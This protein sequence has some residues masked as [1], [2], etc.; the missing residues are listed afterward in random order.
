MSETLFSE[1]KI[2]WV[3]ATCD[4]VQKNGEANNVVCECGHKMDQYSGWGELS[5]WKCTNCDGDAQFM[6]DKLH[7]PWLKDDERPSV[8][9]STPHEDVIDKYQE[10]DTALTQLSISIAD[11]SNALRSANREIFSV[12]NKIIKIRDDA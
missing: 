2:K 7:H 12:R 11:A 3:Q 4:G 8:P 5:K 1:K 9:E 10:L 6:R